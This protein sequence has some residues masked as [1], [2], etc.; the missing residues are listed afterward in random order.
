MVSLSSAGPSHPDFI[1]LNFCTGSHFGYKSVTFI[2][3]KRKLF[4]KVLFLPLNTLK[5][6]GCAIYTLPFSISGRICLKKNVKSNVLICAPSTSA[7]AI[8]T[9][10]PYFKLSIL[11]SSPIPVPSAC[12][13]G[14]NFRLS[15]PCQFLIFRH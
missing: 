1:T 2:V 5:S 10:L 13:I 12:I 8:I 7:S 9:I 6:G 11:K 15:K 3:R 4:N 14:N